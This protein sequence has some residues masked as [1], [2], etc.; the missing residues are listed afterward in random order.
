VEEIGGVESD[1]GLGT[2]GFQ[3]LASSFQPDTEKAAKELEFCP[4]TTFRP[5]V[6]IDPDYPARKPGRSS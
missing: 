5:A 4:G 6:I 2:A 1:I 3:L